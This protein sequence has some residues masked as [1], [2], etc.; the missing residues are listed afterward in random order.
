MF[1]PIRSDR[2]LNSTPWVN[3]TI[4][5]ANV[6]VYLLT[7]QQID[8]IEHAMREGSWS[9]PQLIGAFPVLGYYLLPNAKL[10]QFVTYQ[11]LHASPMHL[12]GNMVFL[13]V[14][15]NSV[16][17]KLGKLGYAAFYIAGGIAAALGHFLMEPSPVLG[18]SGAVCAVTGAYL[19]LFPRSNITIIYWFLVIGTFEVSG[20]LLIAFQIGENVLLHLMGGGGVAYMAHLFG[21][22]YGFLVAMGL[23]GARLLPREPYDLLAMYEQRRRRTKF[24][25]LTRRGYRPW[26]HNKPGDPVPAGELKPAS[27]AEQKVMALRAGISADLTANRFD[28]AMEGYEKLLGLDPGQVMGRQ[29]QLDLANHMMSAGRH[30]HAA[31]AYELFLNTYRADRQRDQVELILGLLYARYLDRRQRAKELLTSALARLHDP[32]Q[33]ELAQQMLAEIG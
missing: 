6:V 13:Y 20:I 22:S 29:Q 4:I 8:A 24:R 1:F 33:K 30:E 7:R 18:A 28:H 31:R 23:L 9:Y 32:A 14:F 3:L 26:E 2:R 16:E 5:A 15:G 21:Y 25:D 12:I 27:D 10:Y 19:V 17:D 11:F